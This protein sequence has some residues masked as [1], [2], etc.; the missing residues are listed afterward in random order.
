MRSER[1][2]AGEAMANIILRVL[3]MAHRGMDGRS[4]STFVLIWIQERGMTW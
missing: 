1:V 4:A 2:A 3:D